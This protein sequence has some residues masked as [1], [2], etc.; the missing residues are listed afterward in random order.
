MQ[1]GFSASA[2]SHA[3]HIVC[4]DL[5][6]PLSRVPPLQVL[7]TAPAKGSGIPTYVVGV[8]EGD[9]KHSDTIISNA[10]CTTNCLAPFVKVRPPRPVAFGRRLLTFHH[11]LPVRFVFQVHSCAAPCCCLPALEPSLPCN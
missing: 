9:Y 5:T 2:A 11:D 1:E 7:I 3:S 6:W 8:N 10:S 4:A